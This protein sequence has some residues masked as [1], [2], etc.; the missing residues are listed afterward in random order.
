M[1]PSTRRRKRASE[2]DMAQWPAPLKAKARQTQSQIDDDYQAN[3]ARLINVLGSEEACV[4]A[5]VVA[6]I[7]TTDPHIC[8]LVLDLG[9]KKPQLNA[10]LVTV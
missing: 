2:E 4:N 9:I 1:K 6:G 3:R 10:I 7:V 5:G 8:A